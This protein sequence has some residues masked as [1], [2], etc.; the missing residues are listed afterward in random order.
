MEFFIELYGGVGPV[1]FTSP[2]TPV[3]SVRVLLDVD[4]DVQQCRPCLGG[5]G[6]D[7]TAGQEE[8]IAPR[9]PQLKGI[10]I[11]HPILIS[12]VDSGASCQVCRERKENVTPAL[13]AGHAV[14]LAK[15]FWGR[16]A[17]RW[18]LQCCRRCILSHT[19]QPDRSLPFQPT[20]S[21]TESPRTVRSSRFSIS[22]SHQGLQDS[23]TIIF[24]YPSAL[25]FPQN[26]LN[27]C[28]KGAHLAIT[29]PKRPGRGWTQCAGCI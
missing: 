26:T 24:S 1:G 6:D 11:F 5:G 28:Q 8:T 12:P 20:C 23:K 4:Q 17:Y 15:M 19:P 3:G 16:V 18:C 29:L 14:G 9:I 25:V 2:F 21:A 7:L 10:G 27:F 22:P 13:S